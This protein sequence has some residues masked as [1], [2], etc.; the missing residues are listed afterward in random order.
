MGYASKHKK[1]LKSAVEASISSTIS[2]TFYWVVLQIWKSFVR[3]NSVRLDRSL[4]GN[5]TET[6]IELKQ[7]KNARES[8]RIPESNQLILSN[9][10]H[11]SHWKKTL[12]TAKFSSSIRF[13]KKKILGTIVFANCRKRKTFKWLYS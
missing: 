10:I 4:K 8:S 11:M 9:L 13:K 12:K 3:E 7:L 1:T 6:E 5:L 2:W